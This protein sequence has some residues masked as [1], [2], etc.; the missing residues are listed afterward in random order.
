[1]DVFIAL[2]N[3]NSVLGMVV[4]ATHDMWKASR[5]EGIGLTP[6]LRTL[7][8]WQRLARGSTSVRG[9]HRPRG[10]NVGVS[11][12]WSPMTNLGS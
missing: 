12:N 5:K 6:K 9:Q 7:T 1:M 2:I 4:T 3:C 11:L 10:T 8:L